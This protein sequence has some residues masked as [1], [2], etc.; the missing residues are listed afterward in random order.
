MPTATVHIDSVG[1]YAG[2]TRCYRLDPPARIG[3]RE[4]EYVTISITPRYASVA[5][6]VRVYPALETGA[7]ASPS[8]AKRAGSRVLHDDYAPG[9]PVYEDGI[10]WLALND[11][12]GYR[13][14]EQPILEVTP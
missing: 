12:G 6:E 14:G 10:Y 4:H 1:G 3:G 8:L 2:I 9:D 11:L 7:S 13:I 5:A